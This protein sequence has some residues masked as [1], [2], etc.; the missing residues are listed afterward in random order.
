[1]N[2]G[3][4]V[5][6]VT[7]IAMGTFATG[8]TVQATSGG[9]G[10]QQQP[11][12]TASSSQPKGG[13]TTSDEIAAKAQQSCTTICEKIKDDLACQGL[14]PE[15]C[16]AECN[17]GVSGP[18]ASEKLAATACFANGEITCKSGKLTP[19]DPSLCITELEAAKRCLES[20][21]SSGGSSSSSSGSQCV[22]AWGDCSTSSDCCD[23]ICKVP[24]YTSTGKKACVPS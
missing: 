8:C 14:T 9:G 10:D 22:E 17:E 16:L 24:T 5:W 23:G 3:F 13:E 7:V 15:T 4:S 2:K 20:A 1:M 19:K 18:C 12:K 21:T 11:A 6:T